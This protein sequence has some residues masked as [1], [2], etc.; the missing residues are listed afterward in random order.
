MNWKSSISGTCFLLSLVSWAAFMLW[1]STELWVPLV[2]GDSG[3]HLKDGRGT[4]FIITIGVAF[5]ASIFTVGIFVPS[6]MS[7][8]FGRIQNFIT[9][10]NGREA[11]ATI[12][13]IG[14]NSTGFNVETNDNPLLGVTLQIESIRS[15]P[16]TVDVDTTIP[17]YEIP[18]YQ[19]GAKVKVLINK[20]NPK[21]VAVVGLAK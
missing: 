18:Q 7:V 21:K 9:I 19:P 17:L 1:F 15:G 4:S 13:A 16:Y 5:S 20:S 3:Y 12:I 14:P 8:A 11:T 6:M 10:L 2:F